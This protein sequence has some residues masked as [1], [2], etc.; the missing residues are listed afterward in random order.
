MKKAFR[1]NEASLGRVYQHVTG[2]KGVNSWGMITAFR[3]IFSKKENLT[4]NKQLQSDIRSKNLGYFPVE[5]HWRECQDPNL[6]YQDC[7]DSKLKDSIETSMFVPN[8]DRKTIQALCKKYDQDAVVY[9]GPDT[10]GKV[11]LLFKNGG[12]TTIGNKFQPNQVAQA[13]SVV[14]NKSFLFK[15]MKKEEQRLKLMSILPKV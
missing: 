2:Q 6:E 7:P 15:E 12:S 8:I 4:R 14:K 11:I 9:S 10:E 3:G 13:Y 1:L 5:G